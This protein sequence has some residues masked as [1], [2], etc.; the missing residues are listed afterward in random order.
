MLKLNPFLSFFR[1]SFHETDL[2]QLHTT[3]SYRLEKTS[4]YLYK[5]SM[6]WWRG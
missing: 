4:F 6:R 5:L 3:V 2:Q 1:D